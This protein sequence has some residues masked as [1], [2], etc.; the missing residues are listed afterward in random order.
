MVSLTPL[1][2]ANTDFICP[3]LDPCA[4]TLCLE[5][6]HYL[7]EEAVEGGLHHTARL[8]ITTSSGDEHLVKDIGVFCC[9][10]RGDE[11]CSCIGD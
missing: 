11:N 3:G 8:G 2:G 7:L 10:A 9:G 1:G 6:S 5:R 4:D